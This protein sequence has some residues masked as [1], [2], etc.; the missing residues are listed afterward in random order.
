MK[1]FTVWWLRWKLA[2]IDAAIAFQRLCLDDAEVSLRSALVE[3]RRLVSQLARL[4]CPAAA[5]RRVLGR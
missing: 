5:L 2:D 4:D 3:R 1:R